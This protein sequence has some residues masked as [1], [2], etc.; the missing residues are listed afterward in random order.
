LTVDDPV[1]VLDALDAVN[2]VLTQVQ[3]SYRNS[4]KIEWDQGYAEEESVADARK[5]LRFAERPRRIEA[6]VLFSAPD[7][8]DP[9]LDSWITIEEQK[10]GVE[11]SGRSQDFELADR[12]I[13]AARD[14]IEPATRTSR[15]IAWI[16]GTVTAPLPTIEELAALESSMVSNRPEPRP[17]P[18]KPGPGRWARFR[19]WSNENQGL[20]AAIGIGI[21]VVL[22][23]LT[24]LV[25]G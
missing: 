10:A 25:A 21:A 3:A 5:H 8:D 9:V 15:P 4:V 24:L 1:V 2:G 22:G 20:L 6:A 14:L 16:E 13:A 17:A 11:I 23:L 12:L 18:P 19:T 7:A